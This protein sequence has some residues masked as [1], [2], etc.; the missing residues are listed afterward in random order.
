MLANPD[1]LQAAQI[2]LCNGVRGLKFVASYGVNGLAGIALCNGVR[3]LKC[4]IA[5]CGARSFFDR[6]L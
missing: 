1:P 5:P 6:T 2:A 3:G 4:V